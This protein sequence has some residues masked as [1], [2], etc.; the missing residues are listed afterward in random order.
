MIG[1]VD[2]CYFPFFGRSNDS[3]YCENGEFNVTTKKRD[4]TII[5]QNVLSNVTQIIENGTTSGE[6]F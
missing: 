2:T 3:F 4:T 1:D 5:A 6:N